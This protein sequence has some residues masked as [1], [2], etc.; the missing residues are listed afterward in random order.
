MRTALALLLLLAS[1]LARE[2]SPLGEVA[3]RAVPGPE[4]AL[5]ARLRAPERARLLYVR[6]G[7][8]AGWLLEPGLLLTHTYALRRLSAETAWAHV[9]PDPGP[10]DLGLR[11]ALFVHAAQRGNVDEAREA[12]GRVVALA[13][14]DTLP[15][16]AAR[17]AREWRSAWDQGMRPDLA[18]AAVEA[19]EILAGPDEESTRLRAS[20]HATPVALPPP[21]S[22]DRPPEEAA[23]AWVE[24]LREVRDPFHG[25][26]G[27]EAATRLAELGPTAYPALLASL[28]DIRLTLAFFHGR[29]ISYGEVAYEVLRRGLGFNEPLESFEAWGRS[30]AEPELFF[31]EQGKLAATREACARRWKGA[32][33]LRRSAQTDPEPQVRL[34]AA[35]ALGEEGL[36]REAARSLDG[37]RARTE[38][39]RN[40]VR[41]AAFALPVEFAPVLARCRVEVVEEVLKIL[42]ERGDAAFL[43][44]AAAQLGG[45]GRHAAALAVERLS[46]VDFG[47]A[48][49]ETGGEREDAWHRAA[50]WAWARGLPVPQ[51][52][53]LFP[54]RSE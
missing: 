2:L 33:A 7:R 37:C 5:L 39:Q 47:V 20:I 16:L 51:V 49:A 21:P 40:D 25:L 8:D 45:A 22:P 43:P 34:A 44:L 11:F 12:W 27:N 32:E 38:D 9:A 42:A 24:R 15:I 1:A 46:G 52:G 29:A 31:L 13:P 54:P 48:R 41:A 36:L 30:G 53:M 3:Q 4:G 23:R 19:A 28:R 26:R 50:R 10:R 35:A 18:E 14:E 17:L 6:S